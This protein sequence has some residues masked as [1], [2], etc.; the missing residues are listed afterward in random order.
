MPPQLA[1]V[2]VVVRRHLGTVNRMRKTN[3]LA[4]TAAAIT[5]SVI[6]FAAPASAHEGTIGDAG[7]FKVEMITPDPAGVETRWGNGE[8]EFHVEPGTEVVVIGLEKE[9]MVKIDKEGNMFY[10]ENS[11]SWWA[12]QPDG[13][14]P[15]NATAAAEASWVWKMAGGSMQFHDH[16]FHFMDGSIDPTTADGA[17]IFE[18]GLPILVN[19]EAI[20]LRG[21]L[22]FDSALDPTAA[23]KLK[24]NTATP[25]PMVG[26]EQPTP[27]SD[28]GSSSGVMVLGL[29]A[30]VIA[31]AG[32][33][34]WFIRRR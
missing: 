30:G 13:E 28:S 34:F 25:T 10:N 11:P 8:V 26:M 16:R 24:E 31:I 29:A 12:N 2:M 22:V 33:G 14:V 20:E 17:T 9:E 27:A 18:F 23:E 7:P 1:P 15:A 32:A 19:G 21:N 4:R 6:A 5:F 3:L